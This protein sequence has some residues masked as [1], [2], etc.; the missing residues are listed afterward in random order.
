ME[1]DEEQKCNVK[2]ASTSVPVGYQSDSHL[3]TEEET[4]KGYKLLSFSFD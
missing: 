4:V 1:N 3:E 2:E